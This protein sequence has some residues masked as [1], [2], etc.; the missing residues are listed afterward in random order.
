MA[1]ALLQLYAGYGREV[2]DWLVTSQADIA[3]LAGLSRPWVNKELRRLEAAGLVYRADRG[4][5]QE[6]ID[7]GVVAV[8]E[9][10]GTL[11]RW[12]ST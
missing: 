4:E 7:G 2:G 10:R 1:S 6:L 9:P 3:E 11:L 12:L 8:R 5:F